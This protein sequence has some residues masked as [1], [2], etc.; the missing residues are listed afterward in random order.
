V[1]Q[2]R[3]YFFGPFRVTR[4]D[5]SVIGFES[6]KMRALL[7]YLLVEADHA[8]RRESLAALLWPEQTDSAARQSLRQS[9]Y[10][11]RHALTGVGVARGER[12]GDDP[13]AESGPLLVTRQTVQRNPASDTW[14]DV[15]LFHGLLT[16]CRAH[17]RRPEHTDR[18]IECIDRLQQAAELYR[19]DFLQGFLVNDCREF[20]EWM[21]LERETHHRQMLGVLARLADYYEAV[22]EHEHSLHFV[23]WL[24]K[25][26]PWHEEAHRQAMRLLSRTGQRSAALAQYEV[27]RQTLAAELALE[28]ARETTALYEHIRDA[29]TERPKS[30]VPQAER[31]VMGPTFFPVAAT[32]LIGR[33]AEVTAVAEQLRREDVR[34][35]TVTGPGGAG[36]TRI[37]LQAASDLSAHFAQGAHFVNLAPITDPGLVA[38]AIAHA[39]GVKDRPDQTPR[40]SL[41]ADLQGKQALLLLDNF[42]QVAGAAPL[43]AALIQA[44]SGVK[45]LVTSRVT[46][47]L[48]GAREFPVPPMA[49]PDR[50]RLP[51]LERLTGYE[52]IRLFA[53]R[54]AALQPGFAVTAGNAAAVVE[55]CHRLDGLPLAIELAAARIKVLS[56]Q[57][58]LA[59]LQTRLEL[60]AGRDRDVPARQQTLRN[61][62]DW[63]HNLL[64]DEEKALFRRVAVFHGGRTLGA[65]QAMCGPLD[66]DRD[67][68]DGVEALV[69]KNLLQRMEGHEDEPRFWMLETI[70]DYA[71]EKLRESGEED[72]LRRRHARYFLA[73]AEQAAPQLKREDQARWLEQLED[74]NDNI[75]A[76]FR[77][78]GECGAAGDGEAAE[79]GLR[80][81]IALE[82]FWHVRVYFREGLEQIASAL[83]IGRPGG[84]LRAQAL[85]VAGSLADMR[86]DYPHARALLDESLQIWRALGDKPNQ[87][88]T[89]SD[90]GNVLY[91]QE[92][93]GAARA[94]YEETLGLERELGA[95]EKALH[96]L[97]LVLYEQGDYAAAG[98][99]LQEALAI[100]REGGDTRLVALALANLGLVAYEQGDYALALA[101]HRESLIIRQA[102][103][104][105]LGI[106]YSL[107][108]LAMVYRGLG[109]GEKAARLWGASQAL[110]ESLG[111]PLPPNEQTRYQR[112][113][114][115]VRATL[116]PEPF[117][118][119]FA[120]GRAM[121]RAQAVADALGQ[122]GAGVPP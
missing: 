9:L 61:T 52:G 60:V 1:P 83:A 117:D 39:L 92:D 73:F 111:A 7:A 11:L 116:G 37:A 119:V 26:E 6:D 50:T 42:E 106:A 30:L 5:Q 27:C 103:V 97:A 112:E 43:I 113:M 70:H 19:G 24:L 90:L 100:E 96:N 120:E 25:L 114:Q 95:K 14:C 57:A 35:L 94:A 108:G 80:L 107:E 2:L 15:T 104:A 121:T 98:T 22:G 99:L 48:R 10:V 47:P 82:R 29:E 101:R 53:D 115:W 55:I 17:S 12:P 81:A 51:A 34:L 78:A 69:S 68:L 85:R 41:V 122:A 56:P 77:W 33:E 23:W 72:E 4:G 102:L 3:N 88:E 32:P 118:R 93:Y 16:A 105:K 74:E 71:R 18:C 46:L 75:Q 65:I 58:M 76:A 38:A 67:A 45:V 64:D 91:A 62:I 54:A 79:L 109:S 49:L 31:A 36:K 110:R 13:D 59:R 8:H 86:A 87:I 84:A 89:L 20:E 44:T 66:R 63:S 28:P 21:L 40:E